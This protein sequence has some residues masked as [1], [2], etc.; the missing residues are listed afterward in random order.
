MA[1]P[2]VL[3]SYY[4]GVALTADRVNIATSV[5]QGTDLTP[6]GLPAFFGPQ[7]AK[8][9]L[10]A[11]L[12]REIVRGT[13]NLSYEIIDDINLTVLGG[14]TEEDLRVVTNQSYSDVLIANPF[15]SFPAVWPTDD[16]TSRDYWTAE[17]RLSGSFEL[18]SSFNINWLTGVFHY[19][20]DAVTIDRDLDEAELAFDSDVE[21]DETSVFGA[22]E[23][24]ITP[25]FS[26]GI[27]GRYSWEDVRSIRVEGDAPLEASFN[28]FSPRITAD[29]QIT[30]S[31]LIYASF[32]RGSK[33]GGFNPVNPNNPAEVPFLTFN[34]EQVEQ[35][36]IGLRT[37]LF[38][39][40]IGLDLAA[41]RLDLSD[42][43]LSQ[44]VI[45][46]E[47][48]PEQVTITVV[49]NV[50]ASRV[51]G[52]EADIGFYP[53]D[54]LSLR[55]TYALADTKVTEGTDAT[56]AAIFGNPDF[57]GNDVPR[58]AENSGTVSLQYE[59]RLDDTWT[60]FF[61]MDGIYA[62]SR[63]A[64]I[65]NLQE[66]GDSFRVNG[67]IGVRSENMELTLF[68]RNVLNDRTSANLF[69]YVD[70]RSFQFFRRSLVSFLPRESQVG[71]TLRF[72]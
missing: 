12:D 68:W 70:P 14:Y 46:N 16:K 67:R 55:F 24:E 65:H 18:G 44:V 39:G 27:E 60:G 58:V 5:D 20:E 15:G 22:L 2:E 9:D 66:T 6:P 17:A 33:A 45:L 51:N 71:A 54:D 21:N 56:Q 40:L 25:E 42:Q 29:Y 52:V 62:G 43:Q 49:Q 3:I 26:I 63:F 19:E 38:D 13:L 47:G 64:E 35:Y 50:G 31:S 72:T 7:L 53:A 32:S 28:G 4:C 10:R 69:R 1:C 61:R 8:W 59:P 34:Q 30:P 57:S 41:F 37:Q 48:T 36:E 23:F 11:G